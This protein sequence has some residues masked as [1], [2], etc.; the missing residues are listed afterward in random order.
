MFGFLNTQRRE[1]DNPLDLVSVADGTIIPIEQVEDEVFSNKLM[2]DGVAIILSS[3]IIV[4]PCDGV[5]TMI[6]PTLHAFGITADS[7]TEILIHIGIDTV[8]LKGDGFEKL[9]NV[10]SR[11]LRGQPVI[12][13]D[14]KKLRSLGVNMTTIMII[15]KA[16][17][18]DFDFIS[19]GIVCKGKTLITKKRAGNANEQ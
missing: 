8:N 10:N 9:V 7:G 16:I 1:K 14:L 19:S 11:I 17:E 3:D 13:V 18:N 6:F 5:V 12:R 15:T 2:G 4:S